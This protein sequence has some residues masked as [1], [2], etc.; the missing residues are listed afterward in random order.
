M[1]QSLPQQLQCCHRLVTTAAAL[2]PQQPR[3][4]CRR[5]V[6]TAAATLPL[7]CYH[8]SHVAATAAALPPQQPCCRR[9]VIAT[10]GRCCQSALPLSR[11]L[12][13]SLPQQQQRYHCVL[14]AAARHLHSSRVVNIESLPKQCITNTVVTL[15]PSH[16]HHSSH[17]I[18]ILLSTQ[19]PRHYH[20]SCNAALALLS[21]Q[22]RCCLRSHVA[23]LALLPQQHVA[24]TGRCRHCVSQQPCCRRCVV[25]TAAATLP[26]CCC[27][28]SALPP[29]QPCCC[30]HIFATAAHRQHS[31]R[32]AA[33][34]SLP[35][36]PQHC[37]PVVDTA[38]TLL[39][40]KLRCRRCIAA[41]AAA[42]LPLHCCHSSCVATIAS[43]PLQPQHHCCVAV[44]AAESPPITSLFLTTSVL[45]LR[46]FICMR[47][48][49]HD[50]LPP[51]SS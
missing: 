41:T 17:N 42:A 33:I 34:I 1:C 31:S 25:A 30:R 37:P 46:S 27:R 40:Q 10:A 9:C 49:D 5:V 24:A 36:Q 20:S 18:A 47:C 39:P 21:Q 3:P 45:T 26:S 44:T 51:P 4:R 8:S 48:C 14:A 13:P 32:V 29:Q 22:Q 19:Q 2:P 11:L 50:C 7:H 12:V 43:F 16:C 15:L 23:T 35:Q 6:A 28:S 38:A